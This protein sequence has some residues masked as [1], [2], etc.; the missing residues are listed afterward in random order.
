MKLSKMLL[1]LVPLASLV[2]R[3]FL[4][5]IFLYAG[6]EKII[7]PQE[8]ALAVHHYQL[9][10]AWSVNL[11]A[12]V[13]PWLEVITAI[14]LIF[15]FFVRGASFSAALLFL[16]FATS[17]TINLVRGLD[18]SCGCFGGMSGGINWIYAVRDMILTGMSVFVLFFDRGWSCFFHRKI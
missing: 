13:L 18:I 6:I 16:I 9:L 4:G 17:L 11:V 8:F 1:S 14:C 12:V 2:F 5:V 10:P 7:A 15:G 3:M